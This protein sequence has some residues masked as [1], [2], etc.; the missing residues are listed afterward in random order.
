MIECRRRLYKIRLQIQIDDEVM[1]TK[2]NREEK[3]DRILRDDEEKRS[4]IR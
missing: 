1:T 2:A 3:R 4:S